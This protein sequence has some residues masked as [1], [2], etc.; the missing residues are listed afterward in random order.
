MVW[1]ETTYL[2]VAHNGGHSP[3]GKF[4]LKLI[5]SAY[6][7]AMELLFSRGLENMCMFHEPEGFG[8]NIFLHIF[9]GPLKSHFPV[10]SRALP[11]VTSSEKVN[12]STFNCI[13]TFRKTNYSRKSL[14]KKCTF[15]KLRVARIHSR[16]TN[17][18]EK[19]GHRD[20]QP[21]GHAITKSWYA[22]GRVEHKTRRGIYLY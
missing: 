20:G 10:S 9:S 11:G 7:N 2:L 21:W 14:P 22:Q 16:D 18:S 4:W 19:R 17:P 13:A 1:S 6:M 12:W 3:S 15:L 8:P 5:F